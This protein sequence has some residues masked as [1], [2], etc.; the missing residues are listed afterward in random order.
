MKYATR[1][2]ILSLF[3]S[4]MILLSVIASV[5]AAGQDCSGSTPC[6]L[7]E[8]QPAFST[9]PTT[10]ILDATTFDVQEQQFNAPFPVKGESTKQVEF[11]RDSQIALI[12]GSSDG[13]KP[14]AIDN[15]MVI[16]GECPDGINNICADRP[17]QS[18]F[19]DIIA[20][21]LLLDLITGQESHIVPRSTFINEVL[22]RIPPV[23]VSNLIPSG[24]TEVRFTLCDFGSIAGNTDLFLVISDRPAPPDRDRDRDRDPEP[25][26]REVCIR[27][28]QDNF[29]NSE[30][31][32]NRDFG[33]CSGLTPFDRNCEEQLTLCLNNA[34]DVLN[35]Q[36][37]FCATLP[38]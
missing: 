3:G 30:S 19:G 29:N 12:A 14:I 16:N 23:D 4:C 25:G 32:C 33:N 10:T 26:P 24:N 31:E 22:E 5:G 9:G 1:L 20:G 7:F 17:G 36:L 18:C 27:E 21:D 11:D 38:E 13:R 35:S 6:A 34:L 8:E 15:F 2:I 28:A 37:E